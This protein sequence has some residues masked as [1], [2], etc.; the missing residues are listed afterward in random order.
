MRAALI[1]VLA[2]VLLAAS[3]ATD[4]PEPPP[5]A[6]EGVDYEA[7]PADSLDAGSVEVGFGATGRA[8]EGPRRS[9]RV[10]FSDRTFDGSV[11]EGE[12]DPLAGGTLETDAATGRLGVGRLSPRW[13][14]GLVLGAAA[15]PWSRTASDR[16]AGAR[17]RGRAGR[18]AWF[19]AGQDRTVETLYGRF[20]KADLAGAH[21]RLGG[22]GAGLLARRR[23]GTQASV[24]LARGS[25]ESELAM[26]RAGRWR[27]E[28]ALER[29]L[30]RRKLAVRARG[31]LPG[32]QS[33]AEPRRS[34]PAQA[35]AMELSDETEWL[36]ARAIAALWRFR[37]GL[38]GAR[39]ALEVESRL[40]QHGSL[41]LGFE[42]QQG[43]RR[44]SARPAGFRQG[45][46]GEWRGG[47]PALGLTLRHE[48]WGER[49]FARGAVRTLT[50]AQV[51]AR[52]PAGSYVRVTHC[53]FRVRS[54]ESL[55]LPEASSDRLV[56]R[57]VTGAGRRTRIELRAPGAGGHIY[58]ALSLA[59]NAGGEARTGASRP[60]WTL[61]WTRRARTR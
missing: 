10:R 30:G 39:A 49:R 4:S 41:A 14:R 44:E 61:D 38:S 1:A 12:R 53:A 37:P 43:A 58:A 9:R 48:A 6:P 56:L 52:G 16:G 13:G 50:A 20:G 22:L 11:R 7:E 23:G 34:G 18:G 2:L 24:S 60:Q 32:F 51:E 59:T 25:A 17:F 15:E 47:R 40:A 3:A 5:E 42:E 26:D 27:A 46:W 31:G 36:R 33:L 45:W 28:G 8:G 35:L 54:G 55:Y 29:P 21:A 57:A 19:R